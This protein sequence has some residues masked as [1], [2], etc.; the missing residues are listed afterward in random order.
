MGSVLTGGNFW[1]G[2]KI[3]GIV[4]LSNHATHQVQRIT[5]QQSIKVIQQQYPRLY[6]VLSKLPQFLSDN[7][8]ILTTLSQDTGLTKEQILKFMDINSSEG[9]IIKLGRMEKLGRSAYPVSY[10]NEDLVKTLEGLQSRTYIQGTSFLAAV[11]VLHEFV[12]WGKAYNILPSDS[13][14]G[15]KYSDY[16]AQWEYKTF[17]TVTGKNQETINLSYKY[18]WKF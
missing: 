18:G 13:S 1:D 14:K 2:V 8:E 7:P 11:T 17:G 16:G 10:I 3:G 4:A 12:H 5:R 15:S 9:Q 6:E